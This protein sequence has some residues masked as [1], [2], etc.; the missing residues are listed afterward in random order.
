NNTPVTDSDPTG[1]HSCP[2]GDC[3]PDPSICHICG[4]DGGGGA[5]GDPR[6]GDFDHGNYCHGCRG[7]GHVSPRPSNGDGG[8]IHRNGT[9]SILTPNGTVVL[10]G[11]VVPGTIHDGAGFAAAFDDLVPRYGGSADDL[12]ATMRLVAITCEKTRKCDMPTYLAVRSQ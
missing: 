11:Y 2:D 3:R 8:K 1:L 4:T 5:H 9:S 10:N 12:K 6:P 7:G